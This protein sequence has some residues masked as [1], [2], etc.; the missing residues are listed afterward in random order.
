M[1]L[2]FNIVEPQN[3]S[4]LLNS[5]VKDIRSHNNSFTTGEVGYR[6]LLRALADEGRS[7]VVNDMNNQA[8]RPGYG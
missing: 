2:F 5:L 7:D 4:Q 8:D 1:P 6:F 3:R